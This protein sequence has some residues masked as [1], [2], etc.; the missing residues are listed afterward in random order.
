MLWSALHFFIGLVEVIVAV[1]LILIAGV[2]IAKVAFWILSRS[3]GK[4]VGRPAGSESHED[5]VDEYIII[6]SPADDTSPPTCRLRH[7][8]PPDDTEGS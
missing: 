1:A 4:L 8:S 3:L 7:R 2:A 5:E 6:P